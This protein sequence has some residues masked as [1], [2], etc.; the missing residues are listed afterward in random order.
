MVPDVDNTL[1]NARLRDQITC[2]FN[3]HVVKHIAKGR[4]VSTS[5]FQNADPKLTDRLADDIG[6]T[7]LERAQLHIRLPSQENR[8]PML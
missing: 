1:A 5:L 7:Q 2:L 4:R 8:H 6:L 3:K